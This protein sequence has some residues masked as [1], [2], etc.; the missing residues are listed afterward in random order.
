MRC[1]LV[2]H[3]EGPVLIDTGAGNKESDKFRDIYGL[4]NHG[5]EGLRERATWVQYNG[6]RSGEVGAWQA[7]AV[8]F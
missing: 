7:V 8:G 4:D 2:E 6:A 5:A 1:L 3:A